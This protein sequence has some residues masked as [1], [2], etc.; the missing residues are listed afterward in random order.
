MIRPS[1]VR[2]LHGLPEHNFMDPELTESER[3]E[4]HLEEYEVAKNIESCE[5]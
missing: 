4:R 5:S 3:I 2:I 1:E